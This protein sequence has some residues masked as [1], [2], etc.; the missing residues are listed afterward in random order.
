MLVHNAGLKMQMEATDTSV[1]LSLVA[2]AGLK[3]LMES[4]VWRNFSFSSQNRAANR[5]CLKEKL[6]IIMVENNEVGSVTFA[7]FYTLL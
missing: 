6:K 2:T 1:V 7:Y 3:T 4:P 5:Q